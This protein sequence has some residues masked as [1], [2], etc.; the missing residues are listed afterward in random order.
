VGTA[1]KLYIAFCGLATS[2]QISD[3]EQNC[4]SQ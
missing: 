4:L 1:G 2:K 3:V